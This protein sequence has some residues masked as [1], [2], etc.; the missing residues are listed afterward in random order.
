MKILLRMAT[1]AAFA[2]ASAA[3]AAKPIKAPPLAEVLKQVSVQRVQDSGATLVPMITWGGDIA[4]LVANG[5]SL[6]TKRGSPFDQE[7]LNIT[8]R[9]EDVFSVQVSNYLQGKS[10]YLRGTVGMVQQASDVLCK[11]PATCPK[12][13][14]QMT[15]SAGGD[16][17]VVAPG[18]AT[19]SE[20][21][22]KRIAV[23]AYGPHVDYITK[24]L[25]DGGLSTR[26]VQFVWMRD[27]TGTEETP[28]EAMLAGKADAAAVII[29]DALALTSGGNVGTGA[30]GSIRGAKILLSTKTAN[31]IIAD[32]Y[33]V[34]SDYLQQNPAAVQGFVHALMLGQESLDKTVRGKGPDYAATFR[35]AAEALLDSPNAVS[36][37]E[38]LYA[39]AQFVGYKGNMDFIASNTFP[40]RFAV[41]DKE[42]RSAFQGLGLVGGASVLSTADLDFGA[43]RR[44][45]ANADAGVE[46]RFNPDVVANVVT[47]KQQQDTLGE[48]E[49][50]SFEI[51]FAPNQKE[52]STDLYAAD[53]EKVTQLASTYGGAIITVEGHADPLEWLRMKKSGESAVVLAQQKQ[54]ARNLS[55]SRAASVR[56]S[57]IA[58]ANGKGVSLNPDQFALVPH[59]ISKPRNGVCGA[60]PCAP[61]NEKEWRDNMRVLFRIIQVEAEASVF[62]P[63]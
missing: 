19:V 25:A 3:H 54:S 58:Y 55:L 57:V 62:K 9:R 40:R 44:G 28:A 23:Q 12:I 47:R 37:A 61:K 36:D 26:D 43:L 13:V 20:L 53:F 49:L 8:L 7:G 6:T 51:F 21:K 30:E 56:E 10:P 32:V 42:T 14:Y 16:A 5:N 31:R 29:P 52:F 63:L 38:G 50:F 2:V 60:D 27:L 24:V 17:L 15:W 11:Q 45:L 18:I 41:L 59:G 35:F 4:T 39:D 34:R 46:S 1:F 48:G 22:G 33:A